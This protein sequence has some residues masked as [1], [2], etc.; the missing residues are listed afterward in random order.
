MGQHVTSIKSSEVVTQIKPQ[1]VTAVD[2][3][4]GPRTQNKKP[5]ELAQGQRLLAKES[6]E[7][8]QGPKL[9]GVTVESKPPNGESGKLNSGPQLQDE[10]H[11]QSI[12]RTKHQ[13]GRSMEV[14]PGLCSQGMKSS[15]VI[16]GDKLQKEKPVG[17]VYQPLWQDVKSL[18]WTFSKALDR[19]PLQLETA[20]L[21]D[22]KLTMLTPEL[23]L[24]G[25]KPEL[26]N[27]GSKLK[28]VKSEPTYVQTVKD[29]GINHGAESQFVGFSKQASD[30]K[31]YRVVPSEFNARNQK[32]DRKSHKLSQKHQLQK[33]KQIAFR[34]EPHLQ[35]I[36]SSELCTKLQDLKSMEFNSEQQLQDVMSSELGLGTSPQSLEFN[37]GPQLQEIK[38]SEVC[39]ET[40]LP[41]EPSPE[42]KH[43]PTLQDR[44][45]C[46]LSTGPQIH[47]KNVM[48]SNT[49][50]QN[51]ELSELHPGPDLQGIKS[52]V[53]CLG[54][55]LED[56]NST[57]TPNA[58]SQYV[59]S[60]GC[61]C[62][63]YLQ[64][65][66]S[67]ACIPE[68]DRQCIKSMC[69]PGPHLHGMNSACILGPKLQCVDT[70]GCIY[71]P[72]WQ[73]VNSSVCTPGPSPQYVNS[74]AYTPG[75]SPQCVNSACTP[76][77]SPP[78]V[79][80]TECHSK[81]HLQG[82][83]QWAS[84][85]GPHIQ[86]VGSIG[87]NP[88]SH[89]QGVNPSSPTPGPN[90]QC[91]HS[92]RCS[93][94]PLLLGMN[95]GTT[96]P[97][98]QIMC[99]N[100]VWCNTKTHL[101]DVDS[102]ACTG[103]QESQSVNSTGYNPGPHLQAPK[104][105]GMKF[106]ESNS[107]TGIQ[108]DMPR[109][110]SKGQHVQDLKF[111]STPGSNII[112]VAPVEY[113]PGPQV[114]SVNFSELNPGLKLQCINPAKHSSGP[115]WQNMKS[116]ELTPGPES[117]CPKSVLLN[118]GPPFQGVMS[119]HLMVGEEFP[120]IPFLKNQLGLWQDTEQ[121][122]FTLRPPSNGVKSVGVSPTPL[123][124]DRMS[125]EMSKQPLLCLTNSVKVTPGCSLQDLRSKEFSP[126]PCFQKVKSVKLKPGSPTPKPL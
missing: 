13:Y 43:K 88:K 79:N 11:S 83:N 10:K 6:V 113:N 59:N 80:S 108:R 64:D 34:D 9:Q 38:S 52:K 68:P 22:R 54:Q 27:C 3:N 61:K 28:G 30:S 91:E 35:H 51:V 125:P 81:A 50:T 65:M 102:S 104:L 62:G 17:F 123:P 19:E 100:P 29:T 115:Q 37:P 71:E 63:P 89:Y 114:Q 73:D 14:S 46:D 57:C 97:A 95:H 99:V 116:F 33:I 8:N 110:V 15:E 69:N 24:Q 41:D 42:F 44:A 45:S 76:G 2:L 48:A 36:K 66:N 78:C 92:N 124:E 39:T 106:S 67:S 107:R 77:P 49:R 12:L 5:S 87:C 86:C 109:I 105:Q 23:H 26:V 18:K 112:H 47:C 118:S 56:V 60:S 119:S 32:Q 120:D 7:F 21:Q 98:P 90:P 20:H 122:V 74:S 94:E 4:S 101:Q 58:N 103:R 75:T 121:P 55:H 85:L 117:Q 70:T 72:N 93:L 31:V 111:E 96:F 40:K 82:V 53:F 126:E 25:M 1:G 16:S 84:I